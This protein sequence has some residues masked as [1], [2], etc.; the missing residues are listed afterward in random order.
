MTANRLSAIDANE[1]F[2]FVVSISRLSRC[3]PPTTIKESSMRDDAFQS[4]TQK[5]KG[6]LHGAKL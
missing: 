6:E 5:Q 4:Q 1:S 3:S 2:W